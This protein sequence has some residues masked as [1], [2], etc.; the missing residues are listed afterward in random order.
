M[1]AG[2]T[3]EGLQG[4]LGRPAS[5]RPARQRASAN[6][7]TRIGHA[8]FQ[9]EEL[10]PARM[11]TTE[12]TMVMTQDDVATV[13]REHLHL[14]KPEACHG[15][16]G[17]SGTCRDAWDPDPLVSGLDDAVAGAEIASQS[18]HLISPSPAASHPPRARLRLLGRNSGRSATRKRPLSRGEKGL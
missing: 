4:P 16:P 10:R 12:Q 7:P 13:V 14:G 11:Q 5:A 8:V 3:L 6:T 18:L 9:I 2:V 15:K 17:L 1:E